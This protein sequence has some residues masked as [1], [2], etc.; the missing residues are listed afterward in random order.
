MNTNLKCLKLVMQQNVS[1]LLE[2]L[3]Y[4]FF[5]TGQTPCYFHHAGVSVPFTIDSKEN[6]YYFLTPETSC[7]FHHINVLSTLDTNV[8]IKNW[9]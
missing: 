4:Y 2:S 3:L 5:L 9:T 8:L 7:H 6:L 1:G